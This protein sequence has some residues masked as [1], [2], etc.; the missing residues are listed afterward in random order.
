MR[1]EEMKAIKQDKGYTYEQIAELSGVPLGTVLKIFSGETQ[2]PRYATLQALERFFAEVSAVGEEAVHSIRSRQGEYTVEDYYALPEEER[3]ELIDGVIY[4]M[5]AP[6]SRHQMAAGE[7]YYQFLHFIRKNQGGCMPL[8]SP[9]DVRLNCDER[10]MVQPDVIVVCDRDKIQE[11]YVYG[12]PDFVAEVLSP[13]T[14][15]RDCIRKLDKYREAG[16][17]EYWIVDL[18]KEKVIA[19]RFE[20]ELYPSV[21]GFDTPIPAGIFRG[22]LAIDMREIGVL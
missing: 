14:R 12:A 21:Y 5:S 1:I 11:K 7:I 18:E 16:V 10:T 6:S 4:E 15:H 8:I 17:R 9:I 20:E 13:F 22:R 3:V 2:S 19:Y